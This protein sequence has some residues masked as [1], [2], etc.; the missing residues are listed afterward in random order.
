LYAAD[1]TDDV[2]DVFCLVK[3][4]PVVGHRTSALKKRSEIKCNLFLLKHDLEVVH[5]L[6]KIRNFYAFFAHCA[7]NGRI[8]RMSYFDFT[9]IVEKWWTILVKF[10]ISPISERHFVGML[11]SLQ[12]AY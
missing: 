11:T 4:I 2:V 3:L 9:F 8:Y 1:R 10:D 5:S 6:G 7:R 12:S